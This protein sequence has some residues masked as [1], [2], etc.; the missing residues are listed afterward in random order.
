MTAI[1]VENSIVNDLDK[2][3]RLTTNEDRD[4]DR[5]NNDDE[6]EDYEENTGSEGALH[7]ST[8]TIT[9]STASHASSSESRRSRRASL[10]RDSLRREKLG[11]CLFRSYD[12]MHVVT[13]EQLEG[14]SLL[15]STPI[16]IFDFVERKNRFANPAGLDLWSAPSLD[17]FLSR[18]MTDMSAAS[19]ARTQECQNRIEK[20]QVVQD[21][22]TFYPKGKARTLQMTMTAVRLSPDEDHCSILVVGN[23]ITPSTSLSNSN[24]SSRSSFSTASTIIN[25]PATA[26]TVSPATS[27][28]SKT[29]PDRN[30]DSDSKQIQSNSLDSHDALE[31]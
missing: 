24:F 5:G 1:S 10:R 6:K 17:E 19:V 28:T 15:V 22:W 14:F 9:S 30:R 31:T 3:K 13:P 4:A 20:A 25:P 7:S 12:P 11:S 21:M 16:W 27:V 29:F 18:N 23:M 2:A 8:A 26:T